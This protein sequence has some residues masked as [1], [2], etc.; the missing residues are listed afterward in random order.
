MKSFE[1]LLPKTLDE[2][3]GALPAD[4]DSRGRAMLLAGGQ[5]LLGELKEHLAEPDVVVNL[6]TVP[7]LDAVSSGADGLSI[8][9]LVRLVALERSSDLAKSH[10]M[11]VEGAAAVATPQIRAMGTVGGNLCQRPRCLYYRNP[12]A[13]CLKKGGDECF[14]YA[15]LNKYNAILGGGPS[16]IVHPSDLAPALV[17]YDAEVTLRGAGPDGAGVERTLP[18]ADFYTLPAESDP[19]RET[20]LA[21]NEVL[22]SVRI[23][24]GR[25]GWRATYLK[26]RERD[27]FDFALCAVALALRMDGPKVVEA[28]LVLGGVAPVPWR[29]PKAAAKLVGS[30]LDDATCKAVAEEALRG[31]QPLS[32][33]GYKIPMTR[34]LIVKALRKLRA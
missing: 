16:Y 19:T 8:G 34:G 31:A 23:P 7:G 17:A 20:V 10:P 14:S 24:A 29:C 1:L 15:G 6:K 28:R 13:K 21:P 4:D 27:S 3:V 18:L 5:D 25:D 2:A 11:L 9:A 33:N 32:Q 12:E 22:T 26:L 30:E